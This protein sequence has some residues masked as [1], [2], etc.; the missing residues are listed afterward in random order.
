MPV[1]A[2]KFLAW[3]GVGFLIFYIAFRPDGAAQTF[4]TIGGGL[5]VVAQGFGDFLTGVMS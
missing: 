4:K 5:M 3:G 2:K 1:L